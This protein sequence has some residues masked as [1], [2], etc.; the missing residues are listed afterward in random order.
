MVCLARLLNR[1]W[2][3][4]AMSPLVSGELPVPVR[5]R[6][7]VTIVVHELPELRELGGA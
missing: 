4:A 3:A 2:R 1:E 5:V 7:A 6:F